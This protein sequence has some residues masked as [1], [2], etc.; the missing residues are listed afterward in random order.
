[1]TETADTT[2]APPSGEMIRLEGISKRFGGVQALR[3]VGFAIDRGEIHAIVGENGAGKSTLMKTLAG[4]HQPDEGT[5]FLRGEPVRIADPLEARRLGVSIVFQELNLFPD[6]TVAGNVFANRELS[7]AAGLLDERAMQAATR[8]VLETMAVDLDPRQ[9]VRRLA[10]GEKQL[11]EI[12]RT[13]RERSEIVI[14][15]EPN[16]ALTTSE[17][18]RLFAILR[19]LRDSGLTVIYVSHRL[20]EVFAIAD[21]I[22]VIR[23]G[24]YQGTWRTEETT[25]PRIV[26]AMIGRALGASFPERSGPPAD[27]PVALGVRGLRVGERVGPVDFAV[28]AGEILGFAGLE[29]AGIDELFH[30]L[31]GLEKPTGG[32][33][34]HREQATAPGSPFA[35][36]RQGLALIPANRRD[37]GLMLDWSIRRNA[38]LT[39]LDRLVDAVGLIDRKA[40][41][42]LA[43]DAVRRL[44]VATDSG[45][46][47]VVDLSGGNQQKVVVAKWLATGPSVLILNDPTRGV[48]IGAKAE[49][50]RL[51]D[52]LAR[53]GLALLF[54]SSEIE[55]TL[56]ISDRVL[57]L[58]RGRVVREFARGEA[59]KADVMVWMAGGTDEAIGAVG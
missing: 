41:R 31:F 21:R 32:E 55:E 39:V 54:T 19:R 58:S 14:M 2:A 29:G 9:K 3:D 24:A 56:G 44:N 49:I 18:E 43:V 27:A 15:D 37:E 36:I 22:T 53:A 10:V 47:R 45:E 34:V 48:D 20:E 23:D 11:V 28:R 38:S 5:I 51:C 8:E 7:R 16:S 35:A 13:L 42:A 59:T 25:I 33:V 46:K 30:V 4:V 17:S 12:A 26:T 40:E 52:E 50:A 6:L 1:M 57:V